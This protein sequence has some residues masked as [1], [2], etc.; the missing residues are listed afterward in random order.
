MVFGVA[1]SLLGR[2]SRSVM[3]LTPSAVLLAN[4][5]SQD[6]EITATVARLTATLLGGLIAAALALL[7]DRADTDTMSTADPQPAG[8][9]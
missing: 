6:D 7:L 4:L 9:E 2:N 8:T 3:F 1:Y 5:A